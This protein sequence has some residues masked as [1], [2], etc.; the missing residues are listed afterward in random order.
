MKRY[1]GKNLDELLESA[2]SDKKV[3]VSDLTYEIIEEKGGF[4]GIGS[5]VVA[6]VYCDNDIASFIEQYLNTYFTGIEMQVNVQV[7]QDEKGFQVLLDGENNAIIIGKNGQ[8]LQAI[9]SLTRA[10]TSAV[11]K[12]RVQVLVDVNG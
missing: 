8:R 4:L 11:F 3:A 9:N 1:T 7:T 5:K 6:E 12:K 10:A 2:A